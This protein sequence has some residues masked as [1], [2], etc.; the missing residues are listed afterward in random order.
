MPKDLFR[1]G[2]DL[3]VHQDGLPLSPDDSR[4]GCRLLNSIPGQVMVRWN[5]GDATKE[6]SLT[7]GQDGYLLFKLSGEG[8]TQG[9]QVKSASSGSYLVAAPDS[10]ERDESVS[11]P[12]PVMPESVAL[13]EC[14]AHFFDLEKGGEA[15]IAFRT[16]EGDPITVPVTSARCELVGVQL[17]N[18][19]EGVGPLFSEPPKI[20]ALDTQAWKEV[21]TIVIGE[22]GGG[23]GKWRTAFNPD[24]DDQEQKLPSEIL[25]K[26]GGWYF[27]RFYDGDDE[28]IE[29][30]DFR[31]ISGLKRIRVPELSP[32]PS[33]DG[34]KDVCV[35]LFHEPEI[36][37][38][39]VDDLPN[40][41]V[42][43]GDSQTTLTI[44]PDYA[45]D[46]TRWL[47]GYENGPQVEVTI[48]VER[49]W[50]S[51][52]KED[53]EPSQWE[54][55]PLALSPDD[56]TVI[57]KKALWLH[58]PKCRWV[59]NVFVGFE[60]EKAR[61]Y[62]V[63]VTEKTLPVP[64][65]E[66]ADTKEAMDQTQD[67]RLKVWMQRDSEV[68]EGVVAVIPAIPV[69]PPLQQWVGIGRYKTA[70]ARAM[71]QR[72]SG[73]ITV[74]G[75]AIDQYFKTAPVKAGR[76]LMRLREMPITR[77]ALSQLDACVE[78]RGSNPNTMRQPKAV[79]HALARALMAYDP[80]LKPLL[81]CQG[82]G[83]VGA[84]SISWM[85]ISDEPDRTR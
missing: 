43:R 85:R 29:S 63:E 56:L 68:M 22:E 5:E 52:G 53:A 17:E 46:V 8:L 28:L 67:Q 24:T 84:R 4:E 73:N 6:I 61:P 14:S 34:H 40:I 36:T 31:F 18:I 58:F 10:W 7:L 78:V 79:A 32:F 41:P 66:F 30:M 71:L 11:G 35:Q 9:R 48:L 19:S 55:K 2:D 23:R 64:L 77:E 60:R 75:S 12:P 72:G 21:K 70:V 69:E 54:D 42:E 50:W 13:D 74:N 76:F 51:L 80:D 59:D 83:G 25:N 65:R 81:K 1:G 57:S 15:R 3:E 27:L 62:P 45:S 20:R 33:G 37:I 16:P 49:L 47:V 26:R 44:P 82:F 38:Q 39:P